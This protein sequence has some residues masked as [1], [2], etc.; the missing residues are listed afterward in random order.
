[1]RVAARLRAEARRADERR[2]LVLAGD[3][4]RARRVA[5]RAL[6][7]ADVDPAGVTYVGTADTPWERIDP[8]GVTRLLGTTREAVVLDCHDE[9]RPNA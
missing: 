8:D 7:A 6:D 4:D 2:L 5:E 9:C 3:P 1:M